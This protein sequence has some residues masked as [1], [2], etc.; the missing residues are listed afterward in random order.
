MGLGRQGFR[1]E[2]CPDGVASPRHSAWIDGVERVDTCAARSHESGSREVC[3]VMAHERLW[4]S[5]PVAQLTHAVLAALQLREQL[6]AGRIR[7]GPE[8]GG[9]LAA[10]PLGYQCG[11][12][13]RRAQC[14]FK[15]P[16][17]RAYALVATISE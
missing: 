15:V 11:L 16:L 3:E 17:V 14:H 2:Q 5:R 8:H 13:P 10:L 12:M 6:E 7:Q 1:I 4:Q 9:R